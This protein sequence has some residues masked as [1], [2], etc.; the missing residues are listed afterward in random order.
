M[1]EIEKLVGQLM[2]VGFDGTSPPDYILDWLRRGRIGGVYLFARNIESPAQVQRML[3]QCLA[4]AGKPILV[5]ID[6]EGGTVAR[7][8]V[9]FTQ[10]P[11][12]MA[13]GAASSEELA[14][15]VANTMGRELVALGINWN[16]APV[17]DIAREPD[18]PSVG[19]RSISDDPGLVARL[20]TAQIRGLQAAGVA[21][22]VKHFPGLGSTVVDTHDAPARLPAAQASTFEPDLQPF[23][24]AL[25]AQVACVMLTHVIYEHLDPHYPATLSP[26][27]V[28]DL[29]RGRLGFR[30]VV[31]TDC[32]EMNAITDVYG[33]GET[34]V[35][36]L[37]AGVDLPLFSHS[38]ARQ[39]EAY[40]AALAAAHSGRL[41]LERLQAARARVEAMARQFA[42]KAPPPLS[43]V[44]SPEHQSL[45]QRA[46]R[47]GTVLYKHGQA[48]P[49]TQHDSITCIEFAVPQRVGAAD[50]LPSSSLERLLAQR[51]PQLQQHIRLDPVAPE[52]LDLTALQQTDCLLL[53]TRNAH[54]HPAQMSLARSLLEHVPSLV[55]L[56]VR[57]P[58]D[59]VPLAA[60][61]S[62]ICSSSDNPPAL[63]AALDVL[64]GDFSPSA[65]LPLEL[66]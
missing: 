41:S 57:N 54:L 22:T 31:C 28:Q 34:A 5:G 14:E 12:A 59:A 49:L 9:G 65:R 44:H 45:A 25:Q 2:M 58:F 42:L 13:L 35:L 3:A 20:V 30:G 63:I 50:I 61:D 52:P 56:C 4:A 8:R 40:T 7:L 55:L 37:E 43:I 33:A 21:A 11:S 48:L 17:A 16:F 53:V 60:A 66:S 39:E 18:N 24:A 23:V 46:A 32:L 51:L 26:R 64:C 6:Q 15:A 10:F 47:A 36:A 27:I 1:Q 29:L 38:R 19:T 62:I